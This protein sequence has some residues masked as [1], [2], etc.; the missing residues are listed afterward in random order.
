MTEP[1]RQALMHIAGHLNLA[2]QQLHAAA[3][4]LSMAQ[5]KLAVMLKPPEPPK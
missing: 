5:D 4:Q 2:A 1:E 3:V